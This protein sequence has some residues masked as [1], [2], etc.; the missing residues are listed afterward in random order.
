[1]NERRIYS[2]YKKRNCCR[3]SAPQIYKPLSVKLHKKGHYP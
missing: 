1:V 3:D 2:V